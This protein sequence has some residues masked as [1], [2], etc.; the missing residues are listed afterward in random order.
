MANKE[1]SKVTAPKDPAQILRRAGILP[2]DPRLATQAAEL[3]VRAENKNFVI[4]D[5]PEFTKT[6][7]E[8]FE[9]VKFHDEGQLATY[10]P[11]LAKANPESLGISICTI[12]GQRWSF[13]ES[14]LP[15]SLQSVSKPI[16]YCL[17]LEEHGSEKV[18]QHIGREPSGH[19][20]NEITLDKQSRPHNPM[21]NAGAIVSSS[22]IHPEQSAAAR[23]DFIM[24][25]W[26]RL[27]GGQEAQ[28]NNAVYLSERATADRNFALA[29]FMREKGVFPKDTDITATLDLY[30]QCCSIELD[31]DRLAVVAATLAHA[32]VNPLTQENVF[33]FDTV[34]DCL[35][36]M[37]SC[38]M[39]DFSG[40]FA[41]MVG[42]PA[43][44]GVSGGLM[45][46]VPN[47]LG[48]AIYSP[49][50]DEFGNSIRG[51]EFCKEM[52]ARYNFHNYDSLI[53]GQS[54]KKDPRK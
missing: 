43:K 37:Y 34:K 4:R 39:Y 21:L 1:K 38:G 40:E 24:N 35:S 16:N 42:L 9:I 26:K 5:F 22:M 15:F 19:S 13:G 25:T 11:Q 20:F 33:R 48:L 32:G 28:F 49:R 27:C 52:I 6:L 47:T 3:L 30:F 53:A 41:F 10:I 17:A 23:F 46:V 45:V 50:V 51:I 29:Y 54:N 44:S 2:S 12:D 8:I 7:K 18:H 31:C 14:N 36:L